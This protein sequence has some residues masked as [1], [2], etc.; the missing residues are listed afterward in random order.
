MRG[1][2]DTDVS[3]GGWRPLVE[4]W[5]GGTLESVHHGAVAVTDDTGRTVLAHGDPGIV[6]FLRSSAKPAQVLPLLA[7]G[8]ADRFGFTDEEIAV[9]IGS[10]G[11]E[12]F[13]VAAVRSILTKTGV[14]ED[15]LRCGAHAPYH[16][17]SARALEAAGQ[18]PTAIHNNCSGKHAGMLAL[19]VA[20]GAPTE[21]YLEDDHPVQARIRK[22]VATLAG[23]PEGD[24][25]LAV[26]GCSAPNFA[27]PLDRA[28]GLYARLM[29]GRSLPADLRE[30][31]ARAIA[32]MR[33]HPAMVAGTD[34]LCTELMRAGGGGLVAKIGAE[35]F[36][37]L[38][39]ERDGRGFGI[40]LKI[41]DGDGNRARPAAAL[42]ALT[43][44]EVL[45]EAPAADLFARFVG[46]VRNH[47]GLV[48]GR[49]DSVLDLRPPP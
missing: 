47:R 10:H 35:G 45:G 28:A 44:L 29:T 30:A 17:P 5:R 33:R 32:A 14:G 8:V 19:A 21:S 34:R 41:A 15:A 48:V 1:S 7:S 23:M 25:G 20:I 2:G 4:V 49:V 16:R 6:T 39:Y 22:T 12:P 43:A 27:L 3:H 26:D 31:A 37:G 46:V 9:M 36:Y 11:G 18:T 13:H 40:A 42:A 38:G 24:L